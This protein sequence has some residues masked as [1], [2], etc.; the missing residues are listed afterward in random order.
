MSAVAI[1]RALLLARPALLALVPA[2]RIISGV[3]PATTA[4]PAISISEV[5]S[6]PIET[7]AHGGPVETIRARVQ[8]T[9]V[10]TS[11]P[12][13]KALMAATKLGAGVNTGTVA[14]FSVLSVLPGGTGPDLNNLDDDG[15][16]EQSRDFM[17]TF[18]EPI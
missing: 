15:I 7:V 12:S 11:Y 10:A 16:Y 1:M 4:L 2:A 8:V 18:V 9:V 5:D 3:I 13:Q 6:N 14:G 17:V